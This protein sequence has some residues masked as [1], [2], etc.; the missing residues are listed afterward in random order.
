M[1]VYGS[2]PF[3]NDGPVN[4]LTVSSKFRRV[5]VCRFVVSPFRRFAIETE[6]PSKFQIFEFETRPVMIAI[7][8]MAT[9]LT[10][11]ECVIKARHVSQL[12]G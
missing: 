2:E 10:Q 5:V 8:V 3:L 11:P 4:K 7:I 1:I 12:F 6:E 9:W